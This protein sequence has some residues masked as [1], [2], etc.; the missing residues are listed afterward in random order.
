MMIS[1]NK[2]N[3]R[4]QLVIR[5]DTRVPIGSSTTIVYGSLRRG[6]ATVLVIPRPFQIDTPLASLQPDRSSIGTRL[7]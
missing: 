6:G 4:Y 5:G 1:L 3:L 7:T 2:H